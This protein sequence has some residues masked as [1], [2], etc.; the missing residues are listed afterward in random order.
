MRVV[1][2]GDQV[3]IEHEE[4]T[5]VLERLGYQANKVVVAVNETFV[6][7]DHWDV[8]K[9]SAGDRLDVLGRLEGG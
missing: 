1:I 7:R 4:L 5:L 9:L 2:N 8:F 6:A 3:E